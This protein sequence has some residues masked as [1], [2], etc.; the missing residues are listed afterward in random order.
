MLASS[1]GCSLGWGGGD[2]DSGNIRFA[3]V[4]VVGVNQRLTGDRRD[5]VTSGLDRGQWVSLGEVIGRVGSSGLSTGP[6]LHFALE[7]DGHYVNPLAENIGVN[8]HVSP[9]LRSLFDQFKENYLAMLSKLPDVGGHFHVRAVA[10][11]GGGKPAGE[12]SM[13]LAEGTPASHRRSHRRWHSWRTS[14]MH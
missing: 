1:R 13:H 7:R 4:V 10:S 9:R 3:R 8:H 5:L 12:S 11:S 2:D 14:L 6:H